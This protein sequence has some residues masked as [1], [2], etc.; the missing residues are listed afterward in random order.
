MEIEWEEKINYVIDNKI[1]NEN[2][3]TISFLKIFKKYLSKKIR[4]IYR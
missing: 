4:N 1:R 3:T 2:F